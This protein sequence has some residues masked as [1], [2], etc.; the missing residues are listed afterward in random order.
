MMGVGKG[1][2]NGGDIPSSVEYAKSTKKQ[3]QA[4]ALNF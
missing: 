4:V 2:A 3:E 1:G